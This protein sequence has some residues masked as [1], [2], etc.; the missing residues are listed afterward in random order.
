[1][2][3]KIN[4]EVKIG[5]LVI[6]AILALIFGIRMLQGK[7]LFDS[8]IDIIAYSDDASGLMTSAP[9][10]VK[11]LQ[12]G[13]VKEISITEEQKIKVV[14]HINKGYDIPVGS[15]AQM[16]S[17][18]M[19]SGDKVVTIQFP[20]TI[21]NDYLKTND[22]IQLAK[23]TD[24]LGDIGDG[25]KPI[26]GNV[27]GT[28][29]NI[30]SVVNSVN[31]I[32]NAQTQAHLKNTFSNIDQTTIQLSKLANSLNQQTA[33][34]KSIMDNINGVTANLN[35]NNAKIT[36]ILSNAETATQSLTGPE[37][38]NSLASIEAAAD[39]LN[40][41]IANIQSSDGTLGLLIK[42]RAMY[43]NLV[44]V[45]KS[46]DELMIDLKKHPGRYINISVLGSNNR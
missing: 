25:I 46:L 30:D 39:N 33:A 35:A 6:V 8:G 45:S 41:T 28:V 40:K 20:E 24:L 26:L 29:Q 34:L 16:A 3:L 15:V 11:G 31:A 12:I 5:I 37:I 2:A 27:D 4:N 21:G 9:V 19:L 43:D 1:M 36:N 7:G 10:T 23:G 38:K 42:D 44:K 13:R 17:A 32:L 18:S 22:I 14:I